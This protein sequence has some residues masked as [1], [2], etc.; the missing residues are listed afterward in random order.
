MKLKCLCSVALG[1]TRTDAA[2]FLYRLVTCLNK[3]MLVV[4]IVQIMAIE[5]VLA[6]LGFMNRSVHDI[7]C[8]GVGVSETVV[9]HPHSHYH[10]II[11]SILHA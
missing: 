4:I 1:S 6:L 10:T 3:M 8:V 7:R 9:S 11:C 5:K 2:S